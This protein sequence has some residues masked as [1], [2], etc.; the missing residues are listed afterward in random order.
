M[1]DQHGQDF[2]LKAVVVRVHHVERHL[3]R[4]KGELMGKTGLKHFEVNVRTLVPGEA[5]VADLALLL[6]RQHSF[7]PTARSEDAYGIAFANYLVKLQQV[8]VVGLQSAKRLIQLLGSGLLSLAIDLG[9]QERLL[10]V[11]VAQR[12]AHANLALPIV[13][14]PAVVEEVDAGIE[15]RADDANALLLIGLHADVVAAEAHNGN[16]LA[17]TAERAT[18]NGVICGACESLA[19]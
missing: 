2:L 11:T 8:D 16:F 12:L 19:Q 3:Y 13:I 17:G 9:H 4:V 10:T 18:R 15:R 5:D 14:V 6:G 7:H 1:L